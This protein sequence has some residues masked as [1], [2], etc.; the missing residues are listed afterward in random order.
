MNKKLAGLT[1]DYA[2]KS[3]SKCFTDREK[4]PKICNK[5]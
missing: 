2:S 3:M 5:C 4:K 1:T